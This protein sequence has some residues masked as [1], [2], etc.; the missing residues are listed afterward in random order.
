[1]GCN[2][3]PHA[4]RRQFGNGALQHAKVTCSDAYRLPVHAALP[5]AQAQIAVARHIII[6]NVTLISPDG[7]GPIP[8]ADVLIENGRTSKIG[9]NLAPGQRFERIDGS[10]RFLIPVL[11]GSHVHV[12]HSTAL[13][14]DAVDAHPELWAA[15]REQV[16]RA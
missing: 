13:D 9:T 5:N 7:P 10:G 11:I 3:R 2:P 15:Y 12:D 16:P 6:H 14:E 8:H 4:L 1:V